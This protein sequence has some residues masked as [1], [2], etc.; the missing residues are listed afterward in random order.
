MIRTYVGQLSVGKSDFDTVENVRKDRYFKQ[1]LGIK[2]I[3][4]SA[5]LRQRFNED[6]RAL[7]PIIDDA[8]IDFIKSANAPIT[9]LPTGHVALDMDG[10]PMDNSKT[11]KEG[12][13][14]TYKGHDGY[15]PMSAYLGKEGWCIGMELREGSW[16][17]QKEFGY[18]LDRV[19]PR[20]H[21]LIGRE[22]K[23]LLRLD[24][25]THAL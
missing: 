23:I 9:P 5:R 2:Q 12:V 22:R 13:S 6:A 8:K 21:K 7:I 17:G 24:G 1:A 16:H 10:F 19:L 11:K 18:V 20:A 15:V 4:S 14:R 3:S 25:G